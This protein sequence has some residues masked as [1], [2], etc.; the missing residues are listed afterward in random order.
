MKQF[1]MRFLVSIIVVSLP[2]Y[3]IGQTNLAFV[4]S[5]RQENK[6]PEISYAVVSADKII[7]LAVCGNHSIELN[8]KGTLN[9]RFHIGSN[10]KAMTA[11]V[12]AK[13]VEQGRLQWK[14]KF[15]DLFPEWKAQSNKQYQQ[16]T[17]VD[18]LSHK[19]KIQPFQGENDPE[20]PAYK[21]S[22]Q[23]RRKAF[24]KFVLTLPP[25]VPDSNQQFVYSNAGYTLAALM[26]EKATNQSWEQLINKVFNTDLKLDVK[27]SWPDNQHN[28]DTW[29]HLAEGNKLTPLASVKAYSLDYT[30]PA[31]DI[32][33]KLKDYLKFIQLNIRGLQGQNNYLK[34]S[35]YKFI[36][37]GIANYSLGW[38][39]IYEGDSS[40]STHAGTAGTYY[41]LTHIDRKRGIGYVIFTNSFNEA[42]VNSV[43]L[44]MRRLKAS[45]AS[46]K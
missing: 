17:L 13:C 9:D 27:F 15:F 4:D 16:I 40:F 26:L 46:Y 32:N 22:K 20:I 33:I 12:A 1:I 31:G 45:Y 7:E 41:S 44:I 43:R 3:V 38:Y 30:E 39:N 36:H 18:L 19:A 24:G 5:I 21:G 25:V 37:E 8:E 34:A 29:G 42:T 10:T 11:F 6:I 28:H 2:K 35:T 14:T 23:A